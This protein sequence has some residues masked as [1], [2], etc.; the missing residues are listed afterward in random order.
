MEQGQLPE[1][2]FAQIRARAAVAFDELS[3]RLQDVPELIEGNNPLAVLGALEGLEMH[4]NHIRVLM[5]LIVDLR[6]FNTR[7]SKLA[8]PK[9]E[10]N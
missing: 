5:T 6:K 1:E 3:L 2:V 7:Q 8:F 4:L 9:E 10:I